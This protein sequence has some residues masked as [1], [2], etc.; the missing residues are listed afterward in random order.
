[1]IDKFYINNYSKLSVLDIIVSGVDCN[2]KELLH[3]AKVDVVI[4]NGVFVL[5][6]LG[7]CVASNVDTHGHAHNLPT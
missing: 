4:V 1:M 5:L 3:Q 6:Q 2:Q 7:T